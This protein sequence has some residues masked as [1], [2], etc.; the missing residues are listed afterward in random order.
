MDKYYQ[1]QIN[2]NEIGSTGQQELNNTHVLVIGAGGLGSSA[3]IY[4]ASAGIGKISIYDHDLVDETNLHRQIIYTYDD[5]GKSKT[6]TAKLFLEKR[7][8]HIEIKA[9]DTEFNDSCDIS[10]IDI[11][12]E[13]SDSLKTKF[14]ANDLCKKYK[15]ALCIGSIHKFEGQLNFFDFKNNSQCLRSL[16]PSEP[17]HGCVSTCSDNGIIGASVGTIG[18]M[19]SLEVIKYIL[20]LNYIKN[21][22]TLFVDLESMQMMFFKSNEAMKGHI[23]KQDDI[24]INFDIN[25]FNHYFSINLSTREHPLF[26]LHTSLDDLPNKLVDLKKLQPIAIACNKGHTSLKACSLLKELGYKN[27]YSIKGGIQS[28]ST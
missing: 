24:E 5:I 12:I 17:E 23:K 2:L 27:V 7:N 14:I 18:T 28:I 21:N 13:C 4:L 15:K 9:Y 1:R 11:V 25:I 22:E 16:W 6:S 10:H 19:Q 26:D 3:L 8:P 20:N